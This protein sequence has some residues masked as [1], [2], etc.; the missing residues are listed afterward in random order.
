MPGRGSSWARR[1]RSPNRKATPQPR[2]PGSRY[3]SCAAR[4][5]A[6]RIS[7]CLPP[8]RRTIARRGSR[9]MFGHPL[10][11]SQLGVRRSR[12]ARQ[13]SLV[14]R[15]SG[16]HRTTGRSTPIQVREW[17]GLLFAAIAPQQDLEAAARRSHR[18]AR[19]TS[20]SRA[21]PRS[22]AERMVF[23]ANWKIYTD[24]FVEGYHIPG[25]HPAVLRGDRFRAVLDHRP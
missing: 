5:R 8:P 12:G 13:C 2:S 9:Q 16:F 1:R 21:T 4:R 10:P 23:Q 22:A 18:R 17:R 3:S 15:G 20:R 19:A 11:L 25:I 7:Q 14:R 6:A 24:N